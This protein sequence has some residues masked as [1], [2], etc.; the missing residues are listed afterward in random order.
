MEKTVHCTKKS[1]GMN[2]ATSLIA[3]RS[4]CVTTDA[5][6]SQANPDYLPDPKAG[7]LADLLAMGDAYKD[8]AAKLRTK[9]A[10]SSLDD[11]KDARP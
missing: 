4:G 3:A 10:A 6:L 1:I 7:A 9:D 5:Q 2:P 11:E 8:Y